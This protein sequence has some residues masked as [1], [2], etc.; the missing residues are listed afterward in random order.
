MIPLVKAVILELMEK[1]ATR[2]E[3]KEVDL[4]KNLP[5]SRRLTMEELWDKVEKDRKDLLDPEELRLIPN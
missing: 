4:D 2:K 3:V 5:D 1:V